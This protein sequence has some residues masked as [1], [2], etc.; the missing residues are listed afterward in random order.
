[1]TSPWQAARAALDS[2]I[3]TIVEP[4]KCFAREVR[5]AGVG[6]GA[7]P[8]TRREYHHGSVG[9]HPFERVFAP[10]AIAVFG[11]AG[12][13]SAGDRILRN[14]VAG[15]FAGS[16]HVVGATADAPPGVRSCASLAE[17]DGE[18]DLAVVASP[19]A[20]LE[21]I[22]RACAERRVAGAVLATSVSGATERAELD[23]AAARA[24]LAGATGNAAPR[25]EQRRAPPPARAAQR[26]P[27]ERERV[28]R[29]HRPRL[30]VR[31]NLR[32][33]A[34][35]GGGAPGFRL[36]DGRGARADPRARF[37]EAGVPDFASPEAAVDAFALLASHARNQRLLRQVPGPLVPDAIPHL[38]RA[39]IVCRA[40]AR[41][42]DR[43]TSVE[44]RWLLAAVGVRDRDTAGQGVRGTELY[45]GVARDA[46]FGPVIRFGRGSASGLA[47]E[48]V[49][50][51]PPLDTTIIQ[52]LVRTSRIASVFT[53]PGGMSAPEVAAFERTLWAVS[54]IVS[55]LPELRELEI[56]P[57]VLA[58][59]EVYAS[60]ARAAIAP[61]APGAGRY[62]HMAIHPYPTDVGAR[63]Q[64]PG[65]G[66]VRCGPSVP[67]TRRWR[68]AS[69]ATSPR[70]RATSGS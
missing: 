4:P 52:T 29:V 1:M 16:I 18:V 26:H 57:L 37:V 9:P 67:R 5:C 47:G 56:S 43:L 22:V 7:R 20:S 69:C 50:A 48:A 2:A 61:P 21:E 36:L 39:G 23:A 68:R 45:V 46:V 59:D 14:V 8:A 41:G 13:D 31:R 30:P 51:L 10:R 19:P 49:V 25:A 40:L 44:L 11:A 66:T 54:A 3:P 34:R 60:G 12:R 38:D 65:D 27:H 63:W 42:R 58:R 24:L 15:G 35:L 28:P 70:T 53:A 17:L 64:L 33:R 55:E 32:D 62:G 6:D